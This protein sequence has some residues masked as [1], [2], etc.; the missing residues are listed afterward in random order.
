MYSCFYCYCNQN[1]Q[2]KVLAKIH[3]SFSKI[4]RQVSM[5]PKSIFYIQLY[6]FSSFAKCFFTGFNK[7]SLPGTPISF[8]RIQNDAHPTRSTNKYEAT[9]ILYYQT[10]FITFSTAKLEQIIFI[11]KK[12]KIFYYYLRL[13]YTIHNR[14][15]RLYRLSTLPNG[16]LPV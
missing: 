4:P 14:H 2:V 9:N 5:Y 8:F 3:L 11:P 13:I 16:Y 10:Y 1:S 6:I 15:K 7:K 12:S